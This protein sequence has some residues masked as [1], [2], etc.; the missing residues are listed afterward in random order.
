MIVADRITSRW[1][2][3][4][5]D[6][7]GWPCGASSKLPTRRPT[8]DAALDFTAR[9]VRFLR[10]LVFAARRPV[11]TRC[12]ATLLSPLRL[13]LVNSFAVDVYSEVE[14]YDNISCVTIAV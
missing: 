2:I 5:A 4:A 12:F 8:V 10:F 13:E 9:R 6:A 7:A 11:L 14:A 1:T 3:G